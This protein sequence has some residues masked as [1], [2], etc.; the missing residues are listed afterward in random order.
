MNI[1]EAKSKNII[2]Q[3]FLAI[4]GLCCTTCGIHQCHSCD[5][6]EL[7]W[8]YCRNYER[9]GTEQQLPIIHWKQFISVLMD[10]C[11]IIRGSKTRLDP[12]PNLS[13]STTFCWLWMPR[14]MCCGTSWPV[15]I[16]FSLSFNMKC[17]PKYAPGFNLVYAI[18]SY[19]YIQIDILIMCSLSA[20]KWFES[21][22]GLCESAYSARVVC[23]KMRTVRALYEVLPWS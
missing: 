1:D 20:W 13:Q 17:N 18:Y 2:G 11:D 3:L 23:V 4:G 19:I 9:K 22:Y 21:L 8:H 10:S 7:V 14:K 16:I 5:L 6:K 15:W 12:G